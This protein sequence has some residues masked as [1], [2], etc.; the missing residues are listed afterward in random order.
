MTVDRTAELD[1][2][3]R[4]ERLA[5]QRMDDINDLI[6]MDEERRMADPDD[7]ADTERY[8]TKFWRE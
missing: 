4:E 1:D 2:F 3:L 8:L 5:V 6:A 7:I